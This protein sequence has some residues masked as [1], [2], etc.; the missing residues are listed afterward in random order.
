VCERERER[1]REREN[2]NY[3]LIRTVLGN[4]NNVEQGKAIL[5][6]QPVYKW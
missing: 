4:Q 3:E 1:E 5:L 6:G 2:E